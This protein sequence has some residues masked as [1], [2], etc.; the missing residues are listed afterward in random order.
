[1]RREYRQGRSTRCPLVAG[2]IGLFG[3]GPQLRA[4]KIFSKLT[5]GVPIVGII[6]A[7]LIGLA[8][9]AAAHEANKLSDERVNLSSGA[10]QDTEDWV[11]SPRRTLDSHLR[12]TAALAPTSD[13]RGDLVSFVGI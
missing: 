2:Y 7:L 3:F 1:M 8:V 10:H 9:R 6:C 4:E 12:C 11:Y 13:F 5:N